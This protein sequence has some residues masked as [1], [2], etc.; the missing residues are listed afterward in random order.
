[1]LPPSFQ[2]I[3]RGYSLDRYLLP[4]LPLII[5][6]LLWAIRDLR[7]FQPIGWA[8]IAAML[9]FN[10]AATRDYLTFLDTVWTTADEAVAAGALPTSID[11]GASWD[12]YHLYTYGLDNDITR[13]QTR[14]GPWWMTFYALASDST[15][16]VSSTLREGYQIMWTRTVDQWLVDGDPTVYLLRKLEAPVL[17]QPQEAGH[18][19]E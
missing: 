16:T 15:Y 9:A 14:N 6:L 10:V 18:G 13:A 11:A 8:I 5:C 1:M 17:P 4:M 7:L 19:A 2:Y 3:R 12:G